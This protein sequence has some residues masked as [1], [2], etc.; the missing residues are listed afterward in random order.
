MARSPRGRE[1]PPALISETNQIWQETS[2]FRSRI[3]DQQSRDVGCLLS[4]YYIVEDN[5]R[6]YGLPAAALRA[7]LHRARLSRTRR[8][9]RTYV[10]YSGRARR[11]PRRAM[12]DR[13]E[14]RQGDAVR[15]VAQPVHRLRPPLHVLLRPRVRGPGGPPVRRSLR[16]L[17]PRQGER[18]RGAPPRACARFVEA[19]ERRGRRRD[20]SIPAGRGAVPA[21]PCVHPRARLRPDAVLAHHARADDPARRRRARRGGTTGQGARQLLG[22]DARRSHLADDRAGHRTPAAA[23]RV[24]A[25]PRRCGD[26][27]GRRSRADSFPASRTTPSCSPTVVREAREA[28]ASGIWA[29][30]LY[31]RPGTREHFLE[32]LARDWPELLPRYERSTTAAPTCRPPR[33]SPFARRSCAASRARTLAAAPAADP[34]RTGARTARSQRLSRS[35][36]P[37]PRRIGAE[38]RKTTRSPSSSPTTTRWCAKACAWRCSARRTSASSARRPTARPPWRWRSAA[39]PTS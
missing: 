16:P 36:S 19:G 9:T 39:D 30:V 10:L 22:S 13:A 4:G 12:P 11:L 1:R 5:A 32:A 27:H 28:G 18:R 8:V 21:H 38:C 3:A 31:L 15:L 24:G 23:T 17:D 34:A 6:R 25:D 20:R 26:R 33:Q 14:P 35:T 7:D 37:R 2:E 29:N